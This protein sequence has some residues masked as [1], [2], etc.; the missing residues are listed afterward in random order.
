M[1]QHAEE[2]VQQASLKL[3]CIVSPSHRVFQAY[4]QFQVVFQIS[5]KEVLVCDWELAEW[6]IIYQ[7]L[8]VA[9]CYQ[10]VLQYFCHEGK[11]MQR[12]LIS[13][14]VNHENE[15]N[16]F[17]FILLIIQTQGKLHGKQTKRVCHFY[18]RYLRGTYTRLLTQ[19]N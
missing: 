14:I 15:D 17:S 12:N 3:S 16:H 4:Q 19:P 2:L 13:K 9:F 6:E 11:K 1:F 8:N 18:N 10:R 7:V 5:H